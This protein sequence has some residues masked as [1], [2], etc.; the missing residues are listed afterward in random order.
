MARFY[1]NVLSLFLACLLL[2]VCGEVFVRLYHQLFYG[3]PFFQSHRIQEDQKL[4]WKGKQIFGDSMSKKLKIF[5]VGDSFTHGVGVKEDKMYYEILKR[6]L[7]AEL[8]V[9]G[10]YGYGTLQEYM[11]IDKY[12]NEIKPDLVILQVSNNDFINNHW[13]LERRSLR[14]NNFHIRP[15]LL[16]N[17]IEYRFPK[18]WESYLVSFFSDSKFVLTFLFKTQQLL[19]M[20][21]EKGFLPSIEDTIRKEGLNF[22]PFK[23]SVET[24]EELMRKIKNRIENRFFVAFIVDQVEPSFNEFKKI[25]DRN[26]IS[27]IDSIPAAIS[28]VQS[29]EHN[30]LFSDQNHWNENGHSLAGALLANEL[31]QLTLLPFQKRI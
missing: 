22:V 25:F 29:A 3:V 12:F 26:G 14:N 23:E 18:L 15:Y 31:K 16:K 10:A 5:I 21:S 2:L 24:T 27:F 8:F 13:E 28:R 6:D 4:G 20:L 11:V 7:N 19:S 17:H 9:Y 1:S 30:L